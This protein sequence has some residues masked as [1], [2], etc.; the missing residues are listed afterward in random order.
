MTDI[1]VQWVIEQMERLLSEGGVVTAHWR[2]SALDGP[3]YATIYG[4]VGFT[5]NPTSPTFKPYGLLTQEDV[6]AWLWGQ[7]KKE[8]IEQQLLNSIELQKAP[9]TATGLPWA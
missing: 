7:V 9:K 6:L 8:E 2:A 5:P 4:S 1:S 3:Y